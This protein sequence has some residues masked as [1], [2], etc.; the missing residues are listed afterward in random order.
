MA[1]ILRQIITVITQNYRS[2]RSAVVFEAIITRYTAV[3]PDPGPDRDTDIG[4]AFGITSNDIMFSIA[5]SIFSG[6]GALK[7]IDPSVR[8]TTNTHT[9]TE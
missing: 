8:N 5:Y 1:Y 9:H 2:I 4:S 6:S 3:R 7:S